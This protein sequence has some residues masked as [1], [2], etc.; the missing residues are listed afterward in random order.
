M[1]VPEPKYPF[2][3]RTPVQI[4]FNDIDM[5]GHL[6]N[7]VYLQFCDLAKMQYFMQFM[8]GRFNPAEL[9]LVVANINCDFYHPAYIHE[10]LHVLTA[11]VAIGESSLT[12]EQ[13]V[14]NDAGEVKCIV[15]T[16]MVGFDMATAS[17]VP[18]PDRWRHDISTFEGREL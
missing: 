15:R 10:D 14:A 2:R 5:F 17:S 11:V 16:V 1:K 3:Y 9:G 13:R 7:S 4:R 12:M 6:N 8:G 18:V